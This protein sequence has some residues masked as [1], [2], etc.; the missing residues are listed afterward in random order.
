[1][2]GSPC[3]S[4]AG[5]S[6]KRSGLS[7]EKSRLFYHLPRIINPGKNLFTCW[8]RWLVGNSAGMAREDTDGAQRGSGSG[9]RR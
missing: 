9:P 3:R 5:V 4:L 7:G 6:A 2:G 8:V 1:M